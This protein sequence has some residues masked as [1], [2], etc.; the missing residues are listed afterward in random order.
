MVFV[1]LVFKQR[2]I[3]SGS[4][5][6]SAFQSRAVPCLPKLRSSAIERP[7]FASLPYSRRKV[8]DHW[9]GWLDGHLLSPERCSQWCIYGSTRMYTQPQVSM[10]IVN[11]HDGGQDPW[12]LCDNCRV[13]NVVV[14]GV[15]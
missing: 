4:V 8:T 7:K 6:Y 11:A 9:S 3:I 1:A 5:P 15:S 12:A 13:Y 2:K 10:V 14:F